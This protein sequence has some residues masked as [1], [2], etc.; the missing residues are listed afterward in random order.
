[1][2]KLK[3]TQLKKSKKVKYPKTHKSKTQKHEN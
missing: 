2:Q 1:M 3:N